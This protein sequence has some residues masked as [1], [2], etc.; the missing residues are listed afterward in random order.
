MDRLFRHPHI[1]EAGLSLLTNVL[2]DPR[3]M[4]EAQ[5][6]GTDLIAFTLRQEA[7]YQDF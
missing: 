4:K 2:I 5:V 1:H 3:F 6:F 7:V